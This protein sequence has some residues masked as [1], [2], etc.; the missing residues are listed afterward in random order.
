MEHMY[1]TN[2]HQF[3]KFLFSNLVKCV[4]VA[5]QVVH[6]REKI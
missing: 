6:L 4:F 3:R 5:K 1:Y 2:V